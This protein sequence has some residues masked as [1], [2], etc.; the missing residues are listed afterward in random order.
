MRRSLKTIHPPVAPDLVF[1]QKLPKIMGVFLW[2]PVRVRS[3]MEPAI[4][5]LLQC[6]FIAA[7][8]KAT[9]IALLYVWT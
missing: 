8:I 3:L 9:M 2:N 4:G 5:L 7:A 6:K 1:Y